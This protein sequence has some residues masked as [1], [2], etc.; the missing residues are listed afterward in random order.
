MLGLAPDVRILDLGHDI[1]AHDV[2]AGALLLVRAVQYLP[3]DCDRR[4]GRRPRRGH[5]PSAPSASRSRGGVL[6]G[7]DNGLLAPAVAMVGGARSVV[8][9]D[10]PRLPAARARAR[11]SPG[12]DILAPAAGHLAAGVA[13][14]RARAGRRSRR[15]WCPASSSLPEVQ[16]GRRDRRRGVVGRPVRQLP[17]QHRPRRARRRPGPSPVARVEVQ[18]GGEIRAARWVHTYADAKPSE[19][20]LLVDSYGLLSLALDRESAAAALGLHAGAGSPWCPKAPALD[21]DRP[22]RGHEARNDH[23]DRRP[24]RPHPRRRDGAVRPPTR[25][26]ITRRSLRAGIPGSRALAPWRAPPLAPPPRRRMHASSRRRG[27]AATERAEQLASERASASAGT[28]RR[29]ERASEAGLPAAG[30]GG[31]GAGWEAS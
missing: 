18:L 20:V 11:R 21:H 3:D 22:E 7:P 19:L 27:C 28:P 16:R 6:L 9:L 5:R 25:A 13:A 29:S 8:S 10:E 1:P 30:A 14:R 26:L 2:R 23:R 17:A 24:P 15:A 12:R 4:R 31:L